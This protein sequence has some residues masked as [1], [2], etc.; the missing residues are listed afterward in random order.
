MHDV[1]KPGKFRFFSKE[2][3]SAGRD[4]GKAFKK[5]KAP[6]KRQVKKATTRIVFVKAPISK[7]KVRRVVPV[8]R[9][10]GGLDFIRNA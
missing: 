2:L 1:K 8:R 7:A 9:M 4:F 3:V 10:N 6:I 5:V